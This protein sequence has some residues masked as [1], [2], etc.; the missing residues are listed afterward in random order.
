[1]SS[2]AVQ[3]EEK[4]AGVRRATGEDAVSILEVCH[5]VWA[6]TRT[7]ERLL[8]RIR[9]VLNKTQNRVT[10]VFSQADEAET[11][12]EL[13]GFVDGFVTRSESGNERLELDLLAVRPSHQR[14]GIAAC[15]V[16]SFV[17]EGK[18][19]MSMTIAT[20]KVS[21]RALVAIDNLA[22]QRVFQKCG[23][24]NENEGERQLMVCKKRPESATNV[25]RKEKKPPHLIEVETITYNG[26]WLEGATT[27][28]DFEGPLRLLQG[29]LEVVGAVLPSSSPASN[30][31]ASV[32]YFEVGKYHWWSR[33]LVHTASLH[34]D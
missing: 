14:R 27:E 13:V 18:K 17:D 1:M 20:S 28:E 12:D 31:S 29:V 5:L 2:A 21:T 8:Q 22:C 26:I 3:E 33:D 15:L 23:F 30:A 19:Q 16:N 24:V 9:N 4:L 25:E 7:D 34:G 10:L 6:D 11:R 32:G